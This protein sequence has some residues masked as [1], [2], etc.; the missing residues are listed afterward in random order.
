MNR[1]QEYQ[2]TEC[3]RELRNGATPE[4]LRAENYA[5]GAIKAAQERLS[6]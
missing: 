6:R 3:V 4:Q 1:H 2:I 5:E